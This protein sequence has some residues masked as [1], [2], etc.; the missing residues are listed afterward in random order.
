MDAASIS[1]LSVRSSQAAMV[2]GGE[3]RNLQDLTLLRIGF[4]FLFAAFVVTAAEEGI[5]QD[6]H[7]LVGSRAPQRRRYA[8]VLARA[9]ASAFDGAVVVACRT[10]RRRI[11][12]SKGDHLLISSLADVAKMGGRLAVAQS[13]C[14][15]RLRG[16]GGEDAAVPSPQVVASP[17]VEALDLCCS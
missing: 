4:S 5:R 6:S 10:L 9:A 15:P 13:P 7:P 16:A 14:L 8:G 2:A 1:S 11:L 3:E 12:W 17:V